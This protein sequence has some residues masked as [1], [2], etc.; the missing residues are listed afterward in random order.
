MDFSRFA[1]VPTQTVR[2]VAEDIDPDDLD[3]LG[4]NNQGSDLSCYDPMTQQA[5]SGL[6]GFGSI[7]KKLKKA[8]KKPVNIIKRDLKKGAT[9]VKRD[10]KKGATIVKRDLKKATKPLVRDFKKAGK[11]MKTDFKRAGA[12]FGGGKSKKKS[13]KDYA[14]VPVTTEE[15]IYQDENGN[16]ITKEQYDALV[17]AD[18]SAASDSATE[19]Q[20]EAGNPISQE[21]YDAI[22]AQYAAE[23]N[24]ASEYPNNSYENESFEED[25]SNAGPAI[26]FEDSNNEYEDLQPSYNEDES[27]APIYND[28][29]EDEDDDTDNFIEAKYE[30]V[31]GSEMYADY[32]VPV[33]QDYTASDYGNDSSFWNMWDFNAAPLEG[34]GALVDRKSGKSVFG[35]FKGILGGIMPQRIFVD[36]GGRMYRWNGAILQREGTL[37]GEGLSGWGSFRDKLRETSKKVA[38]YT[39]PSGAIY[40]YGIKRDK[41][42]YKLFHATRRTVTPY[43][44]IAGA[45]VAT[46]YTG[47]AATPALVGA[48]AAAGAQGY[49]DVKTHQMKEDAEDAQDKYDRE[50]R[51]LAQQ[52]QQNNALAS[53]N[54]VEERYALEPEGGAAPGEIPGGDYA[55]EYDGDGIIPDFF[56]IEDIA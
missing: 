43:A 24:S 52:E 7:G 20:D 31:P 18:S 9:I 13:A 54:E 36:R 6:A 30:R 2:V 29:T 37:R 42:T 51:Q 49:K 45:A 40:K 3:N 17:A 38:G 41:K 19:Y 32:G 39:T 44:L 28:G 25:N 35:I 48:I 4:C 46:V 33:Y 21:E 11:L 22:M 47:G 23:A 56:D 12:M 50:Q 5:L 1:A 27:T 34:L 16:I 14:A 53:M 8:I 26:P 15:I 55:N 10:L